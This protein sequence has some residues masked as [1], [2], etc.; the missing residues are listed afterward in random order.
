MADTP[1]SNDPK[2]KPVA[3]H[4]RALPDPL[5]WLLK[6]LRDRQVRRQAEEG[7]PPQESEPS[8]ESS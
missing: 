3:P 5:P 1:N 7:M 8:R 2:A 6:S 4:E